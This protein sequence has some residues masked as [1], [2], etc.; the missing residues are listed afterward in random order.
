MINNLHP[1]NHY[2]LILGFTSHGTFS[3]YCIVDAAFAVPVP[4]ALSS[5]QAAVISCAGV[6]VYKGLKVSEVYK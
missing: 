5:E 6:T 3:Q 4:E 1:Y 2:H